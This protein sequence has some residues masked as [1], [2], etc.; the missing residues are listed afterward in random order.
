MQFWGMLPYLHDGT[1]IADVV[2]DVF[3]LFLSISQDQ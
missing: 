2:V 3:Y 1:A